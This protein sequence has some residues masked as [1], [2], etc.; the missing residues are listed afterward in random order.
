MAASNQTSLPPISNQTS[1]T[2]TSYSSNTTQPTNA[3]RPSNT[4]QTAVAKRPPRVIYDRPIIG[5]LAQESL[6]PDRVE[7]GDSFIRSTYVD[8]VKMSGGR[9]VPI[10]VNQTPEYYKKIFKWINGALFPG[11][12][13]NITTSAYAR[14]GKTIYDLALAANKIGDYFP[15]WGTCLS[16]QLLTAC[17]SGSDLLVDT[18]SIDVM[19]SAHLTRG[20]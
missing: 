14:A 19:E 6:K 8:W 2:N 18:P 4:T 3:T 17:T 5:I 7:Y 11:G 13:P 16:M 12:A 20:L 1:L 9:V 10:W 15:I